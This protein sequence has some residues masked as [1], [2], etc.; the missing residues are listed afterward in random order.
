MEML[1]A[2]Q[3]NEKGKVGCKEKDEILNFRCGKSLEL[4]SSTLAAIRIIWGSFKHSAAWVLFPEILIKLIWRSRISST[5]KISPGYSKVR[6]ELKNTHPGWWVREAAHAA[7][8]LVSE[9]P[10]YWGWNA[11][12]LK[13]LFTDQT[14]I[15]H[16]L[17]A[18]STS[19]A[20]IKN[21]N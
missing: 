4:W 18:G 5:I 20:R 13:C 3:K 19:V 10:S 12:V 8:A 6:P 7:R 2:M 14:I 17:C 21:S 15:K 9:A 1:I 11:C 16:L